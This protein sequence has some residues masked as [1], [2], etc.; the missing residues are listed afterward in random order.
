MK[1]VKVRT[2]SAH[3]QKHF[4]HVK[5]LQVE[6]SMLRPAAAEKQDVLWKSQMFR[7]KSGIGKFM[8]NASIDTLL[9]PA[10][11]KRLKYTSSVKCGKRVTTQNYPYCCK[12]MLNTDRY[13]LNSL[14]W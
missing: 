1:Q 8:I 13:N 2:R 9:K 6:D 12:V 5:S 14:A 3:N 7:F 4:E 10:Y 11:F